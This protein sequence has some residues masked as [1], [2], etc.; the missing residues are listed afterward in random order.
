M[1]DKFGR[2]ITYLRLSITDLCN[3]RCQ[4]CMPEDGVT[5]LRHEDI[6][7]VE[8]IAE[9][10]AA[11]AGLG[12]YKVRI[13]G[14]EPLVR[15]GVV[16]IC[17]AV[18]GTQG[19]RETCMTTN[20]TLLP[21]FADRLVCAG[22]KRVNISLDSLDPDTYRII[23][24]GGKLNDAMAGVDSALK[25]GF[26]SVKI[27]AVLIGGVNDRD[28]TSLAELTERG[29]HVR[30]IELMP[31]GGTSDWAGE[32]FLEN[33]AVLAAIPDLEPIGTDGVA[34]VYR[35][36]GRAGTIGLISPISSHF[37]PACNRVRITSDGKLKPCLHSPEEINIRGLHGPELQNTMRDAIFQKPQ[38]HFLETGQ[39]RNA[40]N[41]VST[42]G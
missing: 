14:G 39:S 29:V 19:I 22:V 3:L 17:K 20:G 10:T 24:R 27:N 5:K 30:F 40:R 41:M 26:E 37:C 1:K 6:L 16:D 2:G 23:A 34:S 25:C 12:I 7:S 42:G 31:I 11:A 28:I 8:E 35:L 21:A 4:Y 33:S 36:P 18:S 13:T 9:I 38:R 15:R 32:R